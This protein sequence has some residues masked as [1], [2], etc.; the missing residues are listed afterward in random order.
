MLPTWGGIEVFLDMKDDI[1]YIL[2]KK[3]SPLIRF[4]ESDYPSYDKLF[5]PKNE[6]KKIDV[7][8][9]SLNEV[10]YSKINDCMNLTFYPD[11]IACKEEVEKIQKQIEKSNSGSD[12]I[13]GL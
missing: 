13:N 12:L 1:G 10:F 2:Y 8:S 11:Y 7:A 5:N 4:Y 3:K 6:C 9:G